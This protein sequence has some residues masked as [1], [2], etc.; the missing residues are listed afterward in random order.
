M[1]FSMTG[2]GTGCAEKD[3][4]AVSVEIRSVNHRFL[5]LHIRLPREYLFLE[6]GIQ[7]WVRSALTRGRVDVSASIQKTD[8]SEY[9][10]NSEMVTSYLDA[11][12]KLKD[13][14]NLQDSL[15]LRTLLNLPGV[16]KNGDT[17]QVD[18]SGVLTDL[19]KQSVQTALEG[20]LEMRRREG[21]ALR[22]DMLQNL[23]TIEENTKSIRKLSANAAAECLEKLNDRLAQL[24]SQRGIDPQ[25]LAQ[26]AALM[27]D[28][29]DIS[30][31]I[32]RLESHTEQYRMLINAEE[33]VGKK[34]DF[35][36]QELQRETNTILSKSG[37]MEV[38]HHAIAIKTDVEKLRE[39]VQNVE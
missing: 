33:K 14:F 3:G 32:A 37:N 25:R 27:A 34:L 39:Q 7:Q 23:A 9:V 30:E 1:I 29:C 2:Y 21:E 22:V 19:L 31:E 17:D 18:T 6:R 20:V 35:L 15:D 28:K 26:E 4:T 24:L 5:D 11:A 36:L 10:I 12:A 13:E 8:E 38:A 16:L